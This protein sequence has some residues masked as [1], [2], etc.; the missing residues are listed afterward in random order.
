MDLLKDQPWV[1]V[2]LYR[3]NLLEKLI[4][5]AIHP[6]VARLKED[7]LISQYFF[8]R[9]WENGSHVR[10]R[11]KLH[12]REKMQMVKDLI[13]IHFQNYFTK[14]PDNKKIVKSEVEFDNDFILF[15]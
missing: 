14:Y 15:K 8:I 2:Y 13:L 1:S 10:L 7:Q 12:K 6:F 11:L 3:S 4:T 5:D 9:Y